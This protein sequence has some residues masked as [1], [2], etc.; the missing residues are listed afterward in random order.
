MGVAAVNRM[1]FLFGRGRGGSSRLL[2]DG[3]IDCR[4]LVFVDGLQ[5]WLLDNVVG[6]F[7]EWR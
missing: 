4:D 7:R 3:M 5:F 2:L 6:C 1:C